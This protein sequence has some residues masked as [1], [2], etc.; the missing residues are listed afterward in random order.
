MLRLPDRLLKLT[1]IRCKCRC[2][3]HALLG[4]GRWA[5][6]GPFTVLCMWLMHLVTSDLGFL[7]SRVSSLTSHRQALGRGLNLTR[8]LILAQVNLAGGK[9]CI[10]FGQPRTVTT[11]FETKQTFLFLT[12]HPTRHSVKMSTQVK[13]LVFSVQQHHQSSPSRSLASADRSA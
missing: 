4:G 1:L 12:I 11:E 13:T 8:D 5:V 9:E 7:I 10:E 3:R 2:G 6:Q